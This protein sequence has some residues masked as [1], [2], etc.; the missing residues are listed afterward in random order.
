[1]YPPP[2][3]NLSQ[4]HDTTLFSEINASFRKTFWF[5][6]FLFDICR[7]CGMMVL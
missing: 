4:L 6:E 2:V 3:L 5:H 7:D 1:M